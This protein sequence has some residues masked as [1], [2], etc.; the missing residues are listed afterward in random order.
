MT[1]STPAELWAGLEAGALD[2]SRF[3]HRDHVA[4]AWEALRLRP[5]EEAAARFCAALRA[6]ATRAGQADRY[7]EEM[8][9]GFLR[10]IEERR[11][12]PGAPSTWPGF[13]AAFPELFDRADP[14]VRSL[15]EGAAARRQPR[16]TISSR[17]SR[18]SI[19]SPDASL[20]TK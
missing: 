15:F 3:H 10:L 9:R 6:F 12:R 20:G 2:P 17:G 16:D 7:D 5:Y 14:A 4:A 1:G 13:R 19:T 18:G 11:T 8:T